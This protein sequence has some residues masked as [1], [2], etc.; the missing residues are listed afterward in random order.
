[1]VEWTCRHIERRDG[2]IISVH[3][4][5]DRG[6]GTATAEMAL[7][8]DDRLEGCLF[9]NG[10]RTGNLDIVNVA[11]NM[12]IQGVSPGLDFPTSMPFV[13]RS[14]IATSCPC[15]PAT[16]TW[17]IW[18]TSFSGSHQDAIK[19]A[20]AARKEGEIWEIT[21]F[22]HRPQRSGS[23]LRGGDSRQQ[24]VGQGWH[25]LSAGDRIRCAIA[26]SPAN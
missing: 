23:Q 22:A 24:P 6:T 26:A 13:P 7:L 8:A 15:I 20:F 19:K 14:S 5:N 3:P 1:M 12:Y 25:C 4:H 18:S 16:R 2:V 11:L 9:G 17:A 10:E 21:L